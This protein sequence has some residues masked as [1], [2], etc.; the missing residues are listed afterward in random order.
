MNRIPIQSIAAALLLALALQSA[1]AAAATT[2]VEIQKFAFLA[3][4]ITVA[5][6]TTV[7]WVNHDEAPHTVIGDQHAFASKGLDTGDK[8]D[9]TFE[10]EGDYR[11]SCSLHPFMIGTVHVRRP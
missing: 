4:E 5:P 9:F 11:Y 10:R 2:V 7:E 1:P 3:S 8:F 6:G